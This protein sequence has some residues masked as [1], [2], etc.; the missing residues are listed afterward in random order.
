MGGLRGIVRG[1][2]FVRVAILARVL[3]PKDFGVYGVASLVLAFLEILTETG[4]N[5]FLVQ[6]KDNFQKYLDTAWIISI[7]RGFVISLTLF[8]VAPLIAGFFTSPESS[9]IIRLIALVPLIRGFINPSIISYLKDLQFSKEFRLRSSVYVFDGTMAI[10]FSLILRN[11]FGIVIGIIAGVLLELVLSY[12]FVKPHPSF[13]FNLN[14]A[15]E[16]VAKGKWVTLSGIFNY[17]AQ[18]GDDIVVA[19][20]LG[21]TPLGF[22]QVAYKIS[23][24]PLTEVSEAVGKVTFPTYTKDN[25]DKRVLRSNFTHTS[26]I[27]FSLVLVFGILLY[28][29]PDIVI[30]VV[31]GEKWLSAVAVLKVL[32]IFGVVRSGVGLCYSLFLAVGRQDVVAKIC[33]AQFIVLAIFIFPMTRNFGILGA[34][35]S[36]IISSIIPLPIVFYYLNKIFKDDYES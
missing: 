29:F 33:L 24:L 16:I 31:L 13:T 11:P 36:A 18:N 35:Y 3:S 5:V 14:H 19:R 6:K 2:G 30:K 9:N 32:A 26:I 25:E 21:N 15:K 10:I 20:I 1:F 22:Y 28:L 34:G 27:V 23:T 7:T 17:L 8:F 4:V 12:V